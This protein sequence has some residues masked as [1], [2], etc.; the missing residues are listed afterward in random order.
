MRDFNNRM[1]MINH[2]VWYCRVYKALLKQNYRRS[3]NCSFFK[4][5]SKIADFVINIVLSM[6]RNSPR[7]RHFSRLLWLNKSHNSLNRIM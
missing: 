6:V 2:F 4:L 5:V 1:K 7:I 3:V